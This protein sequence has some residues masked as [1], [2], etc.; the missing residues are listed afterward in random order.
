MQLH[1]GGD[2]SHDSVQAVYSHTVN[3]AIISEQLPDEANRVSL[4]VIQQTTHNLEAFFY[5]TTIN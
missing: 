2:K 4:Y 1:M 5:K 3:I